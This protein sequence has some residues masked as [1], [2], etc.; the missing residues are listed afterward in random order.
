MPFNESGWS[1]PVVF[2]PHHIEN[3][4]EQAQSRLLAQY[5]DKPV[6]VAL[7]KACFGSPAQR[8]A[9]LVF[10]LLELLDIDNAE[11]VILDNI[12]RIVG[13]SRLGKND[14][15]YRLLIKARIGK[16]TSKGIWLHIVSTW[17]NLT[18][19]TSVALVELFPAGI[20]IISDATVPGGDI[21]FVAGFIQDVVAAG[22]ELD[23]FGVF[24]EAGTF[25]FSPTSG[26]FSTDGITGGGKFY[27]KQ[28]G[29]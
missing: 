16:N 26:G 2:Y 24:P 23:G 6:F 11:G 7:I 17:K 8:M 20:L 29:S 9:D 18:G 15:D 22:V 27:S 5:Q 1:E 4:V 14:A 13:Q 19:A 10:S 28:F 25:G 3:H 21:D 12:G